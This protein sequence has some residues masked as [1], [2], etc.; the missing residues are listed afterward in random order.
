[1]IANQL[2]T[3][4][5]AVLTTFSGFLKHKEFKAIA[6][7]SLSLAQQSG[8]TKILV[9]TSQTR[10]IQ[11]QSQKWIDGEWFPKALE[12][13]VRHMAFLIPEDI[14]G[15]MSVEAT[16]KQIRQSGQ[17]EIQYFGSLEEARN[18]LQSVS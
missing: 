15:K 18:W 2:D 14:F 7:E 3:S 10:V 4:F 12:T 1:M 11:Q 9:D 6:L 8:F 17:I 13:G 16:N 5:Q